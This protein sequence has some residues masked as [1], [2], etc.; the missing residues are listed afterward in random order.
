MAAN[1]GTFCYRWRVAAPPDYGPT[2]GGETLWL[3]HESS[4]Q[5]ISLVSPRPAL[6]AAVA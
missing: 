1:E 6:I 4:G 3:I 5:R 2:V